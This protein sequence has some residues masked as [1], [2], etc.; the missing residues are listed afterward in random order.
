MDQLETKMG[1]EKMYTI[2]KNNKYS[3]CIF[4]Q[5]QNRHKPNV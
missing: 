1:M 5:F 4:C 2:N 3:D